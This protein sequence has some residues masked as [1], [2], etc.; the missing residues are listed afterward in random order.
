[1]KNILLYVEPACFRN[2]PQMLSVWVSWVAQ[3]VRMENAAG[4]GRFN[5]AIATSPWLCDFFRGTGPETAT[6]QIE[7]SP[8]RVLEAFEGDRYRYV[9]DLYAP[10]STPPVN[11]A[12]V[13]VFEEIRESFNPDLILS[14][15]QNR[16][17]ETVFHD[18]RHV[19]SEMAPLP[20]ITGQSAFFFDPSGHQT[21]NLLRKEASRL[22]NIILPKADADEVLALWQHNVRDRCVEAAKTRGLDQWLAG[23]REEGRPVALLAFQP[24]DWLTYEGAYET[25]PLDALLMR[26]LSDLPSEW[27]AV[28]TYHPLWRLPPEMEAAIAREFPNFRPI[29]E[30]LSVGVSEPLLPFVE[31]VLTISS[32]VGM[33]GLLDGKCVLTYGR[34]MLDGLSARSPDELSTTPS[35]TSMQRAAVMAFLSNGYCHDVHDCLDRH[36]YMGDLWSRIINSKD[37]GSDYF[38]FSRWS[39]KIFGKLLGAVAT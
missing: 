27:L 32:S 31:A 8:R 26:W 17:I 6:L 14:Y 25:I 30:D 1:M 11:Q 34:S 15:A 37:P 5:F 19:F 2:D 7:V 23:I 3:F 16:Y 39:P 29:P 22:Q 24:P 20:R 18:K 4:G 9:R 38:D 33:M 35:L 13:D 10:A 28:A 36:G 21:A 12:L